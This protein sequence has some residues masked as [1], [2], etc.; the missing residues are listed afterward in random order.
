MQQSRLHSAGEA[1]P[2]LM[3]TNG[4][5]LVTYPMRFVYVIDHP[6]LLVN[7]VRLLLRTTES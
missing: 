4:L 1:P 5:V 6:I 3:F 2:L 7:S